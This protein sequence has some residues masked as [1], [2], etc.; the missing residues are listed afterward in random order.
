MNSKQRETLRKV[1]IQLL[2]SNDKNEIEKIRVQM[3][4][5]KKEFMEFI[6]G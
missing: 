3:G 1:L 4:W 5:S 2:K 6:C